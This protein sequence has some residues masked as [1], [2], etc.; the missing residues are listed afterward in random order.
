MTGHHRGKLMAPSA[1]PLSD[2][3]AQTVPGGGNGSREEEEEDD[4][5][6]DQQHVGQREQKRALD[7]TMHRDEQIGQRQHQ[8]VVGLLKIKEPKAASLNESGLFG[9]AQQPLTAAAAP[10]ASIEQLLLGPLGVRGTALYSANAFLN[11]LQQQREAAMAQAVGWQWQFETISLK[12][13]TIN[14][15]T[16]LPSAPPI[17]STQISRPSVL[18]LNQS[19]AVQN[20]PSEPSVKVGQK[21]DGKKRTASNST[22]SRVTATEAPKGGGGANADAKVP[23]PIAGGK[24]RYQCRFCQK[25]FPRSANLTRHLRTHTGEQP[26]KVKT[27]K[28]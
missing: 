18:K 23:A 28:S 26:Y 7:L 25:V 20:H 5:Y 2:L 24:E 9:A 4:N 13:Q 10:I 6:N 11:L 16:L 14:S 15:S 17:H 21:A 19:K 1:S 3:S 27:V 22:R 12:F 8:P